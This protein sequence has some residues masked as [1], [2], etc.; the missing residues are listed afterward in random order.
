[1]SYIFGLFLIFI[2]INTIYE[3]CGCF[4]SDLKIAQIEQILRLIQQ[5]QKNFYNIWYTIKERNQLKDYFHLRDNVEKE[6]FKNICKS[7]ANYLWKPFYF[8]FKKNDIDNVIDFCKKM[9]NCY[10]E[11]EKTYHT[12]SKLNNVLHVLDS[13]N[14]NIQINN[15]IQ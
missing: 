1:V 2:F 11:P 12:Q 10:I 9:E 8:V 5:S 6:N 3:S 4:K 14:N 15:N 13:N 7:L